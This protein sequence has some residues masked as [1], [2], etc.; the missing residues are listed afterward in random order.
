MRRRRNALLAAVAAG[1]ILLAGCSQGTAA[2]SESSASQAADD[3]AIAFAQCLR[4]AGF[5]VPD[6]G[7]ETAE[8]SDPGGD[9]A[10]FNEAT[11]ACEEKLGAPPGQEQAEADLNNPELLEQFTKAAECLRRLGYD[12]ADPVPGQG[13]TLPEVPEEAMQQC[14][15]EQGG[16]S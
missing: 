10:S 7:E 16:G 1:T 12:V 8:T 3:Y 6:P 15:A 5:N 9:A 11:R 14:F 13:L 4:D 2:S